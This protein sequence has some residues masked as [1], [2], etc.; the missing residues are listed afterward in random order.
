VQGVIHKGRPH[1]GVGGMAQLGQKQTRGGGFSECGRSG[2]TKG[3][4]QLPP[5]AADEG[6][7]NSLTKNILTT[8]KASQPTV[9]YCNKLLPFLLPI[10]SGISYSIG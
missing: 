10:C 3:G 9:A 8:I 1:G 7:Q 4:G 5:G 6:A 2:V